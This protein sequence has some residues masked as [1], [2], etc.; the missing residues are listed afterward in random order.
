MARAKKMPE[1]GFTLNVGGIEDLDDATANALFEAGCDDA[2]VGMRAG[3][4]TMAFHREAPTFKDAVFSAIRAVQ[5]AGI[6]ATVLS[7][8]ES[9][10]VTQADI[11]RRSGRSRQQI[12]Q[13]V[14]GERG[15][16]F[17]A[18]VCEVEAGR[19][20]WDWIEVAA[21]LNERGIVSDE[22]LETSRVVATINAVLA[23]AQERRRNP[24]LAS[25]ALALV[26]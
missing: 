5:S 8:D 10:T 9:I 17:P 25:E 19:P 3:L 14:K 16:N 12:G 18:P 24:E 11:A 21:W 6:G 7:V 26:G 1:H 20:F 15:E 4:V 2:T 23:M 13:Y 22:M